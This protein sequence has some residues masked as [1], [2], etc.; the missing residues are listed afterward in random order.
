[1]LSAIRPLFAKKPLIKNW[2]ILNPKS[3]W[4]A[5]ISSEPKLTPLHDIE[6]AM[7]VTWTEI[8]RC[9]LF[10]RKQINRHLQENTENLP[11]ISQEEYETRLNEITDNCIIRWLDREVGWVLTLRPGKTLHKGFISCYTGIAAINALKKKT[12]YPARAYFFSLNQT[13]TQDVVVD[14]KY[15]G[16][17]ARLLPFLLEQED[18]ENFEID[19]SIKD[20]IAIANLKFEFATFNGIRVPCVFAPN[21]IT[22]PDDKELL[23]GL[24]YSLPYL[25]KMLQNNNLFKL[26]NRETLAPIDPHLYPQKMIQVNLEGLSYSFQVSRLRIIV[27]KHFPL[28]NY[29]TIGFDESKNERYNITVSD[30]AIYEGLMASP[31]AKI[32]T[33]RP[34]ISACYSER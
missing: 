5:D 33:V 4:F 32:I 12:S 26:L 34:V 19:P 7:G 20:K 30:A 23:L 21:D 27:G 8:I 18:L 16:N 11:I 13:Q 15:D 10:D 31:D 22:A 9:N 25:L 24:N 6:S 29:Q 14:A 1:M 2:N 28:L 17:I 3:L